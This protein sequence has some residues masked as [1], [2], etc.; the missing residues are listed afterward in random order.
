MKLIPR[1]REGKF[2]I[3]QE[4]SLCLFAAG[5]PKGNHYSDLHY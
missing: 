3:P 5:A 4:F 1:A 2:S